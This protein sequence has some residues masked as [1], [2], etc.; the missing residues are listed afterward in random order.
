VICA[1]Y[2]GSKP[3]IKLPQYTLPSFDNFT[4]AVIEVL[5]AVSEID[6]TPGGAYSGLTI[7]AADSTRNEA[8]DVFTAS[9][10]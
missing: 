4:V 6:F 2:E 1:A 5:P 9:H 3:L 7:M 10:P 8:T